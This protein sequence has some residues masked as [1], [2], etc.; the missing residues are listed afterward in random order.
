MLFF[1]RRE[2][3]RLASV[4]ARVTPISAISITSSL[5]LIT[6]E[7]VRC[8]CATCD[9]AIALSLDVSTVVAAWGMSVIRSGYKVILFSPTP[10]QHSTG[11]LST[12]FILSRK[13]LLPFMTCETLFSIGY[14]CPRRPRHGRSGRPKSLRPLEM[15]KTP[16]IFLVVW[17]RNSQRRRVP[18]SLRGVLS[19]I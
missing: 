17:K 18:Q 2:R 3:L 1:Q 9:A 16:S 14:I 6:R 13:G 19:A 5:P 7:I 12:L 11:R 15:R 8:S 4:H 10:H